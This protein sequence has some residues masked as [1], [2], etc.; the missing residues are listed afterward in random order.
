MSSK[1]DEMKEIK[2]QRVQVDGCGWFE[3]DF[4]ITDLEN[5]ILFC[6]NSCFDLTIY[7][8]FL[9]FTERK[10]DL[11]CDSD[12]RRE[13]II[14]LTNIEK[15]EEFII[16]KDKEIHLHGKIIPNNQIEINSDFHDNKLQ[17][18]LVFSIKYLN[19]FIEI[20]SRLENLPFNEEIT[21]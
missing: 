19:R 9:R 4:L 3:F 7:E 13:L 10:C 12:K 14:N 6:I 11:A 15:I 20:L 5:N 18:S 2:I 1:V 17:A 16:S 8:N 21:I